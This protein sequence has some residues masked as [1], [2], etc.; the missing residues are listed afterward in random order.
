MIL[1]NSDLARLLLAHGADA[2]VGYHDLGVSA[3]QELWTQMHVKCGRA[4]QL[5]MDLGNREI[6]ELLLDHGAEINL[7]Q[8]VWQFHQ[9]NMIPRTVYLKITADLRVASA[10]REQ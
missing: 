2:N 4:I 5:A 1:R 8:P 9:C 3:A 6:V 7:A 10:K